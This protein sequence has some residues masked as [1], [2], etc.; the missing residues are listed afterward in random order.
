MFSYTETKDSLLLTAPS[1]NVE[2]GS[3]IQLRFRPKKGTITKVVNNGTEYFIK[4]N[5]VSPKFDGQTI[6]YKDSLESEVY[7]ERHIYTLDS[8]LDIDESFVISKTNPITGGIRLPAGIDK[9]PGK[10][11]ADVPIMHYRPVGVKRTIT[12]PNPYG[13]LPNPYVIHPAI[14]YIP[15]GFGGAEYWMAYTPLNGNDS[16]Y[17]NPCVV[18][19]DDVYG[20]WRVPNGLV[21]PLAVSSNVGAVY[22][23]DTH[24]YYDSASKRLI[25]MWNCKGE[26]TLNKLKIRTSSDGITWTPEITIWAGAESESDMASP[27][28]WY[29]PVTSKWVCV[30]HNAGDVG[31]DVRRI[32]SSTLEAGWDSTP[33]VLS[34]PAPSGRKWWHSWFTRLS[35]GR[36]V[37]VAMDNDGGLG[38]PGYIYV[39]QSVDGNIYESAKIDGGVNTEL[40]RPTAVFIERNGQLEAKVIHSR[41]NT[42]FFFVQDLQ[43]RRH[44][45]YAEESVALGGLLS[46]ASRAKSR[47]ILFADDFNRADS[48]TGLGVTLDNKAW[49]QYSGAALVGILNGMTYPATPAGNDIATIDVGTTAYSVYAAAGV[50]GALS[51]WI[52]VNFSNDANFVRIG[53]VGA[54]LTVQK[55]KNTK[56]YEVVFDATHP[57]RQVIGYAGDILRCDCSGASMRIFYNGEMVHEV[58]GLLE[59]GYTKVGIQCS[60][61]SGYTQW[62]AIAVEAI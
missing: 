54:R 40:Y 36:I 50:V 35:S 47:S 25:V 23:R 33:V 2:A 51:G 41:L 12:V 19:A 45:T 49:V 56:V 61:A 52:L 4:P 29:D 58:D 59:P 28:F 27:S 37:G 20:P 9:L 26:S 21:N 43:D 16:T 38:T 5:D 62:D 53:W 42:N 13:D 11:P 57:V 24:I 39:S 15:G 3:F 32:T 7:I 31:R 1:M 30:G 8:G 44:R 48:A 10:I 17:E 60:G 46:L 55:Y 6:V 18:C 14:C 22:N 34:F